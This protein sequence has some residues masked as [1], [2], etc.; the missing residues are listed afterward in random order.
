MAKRT[1]TV[2]L[3]DGS[4]ATRTTTHAYTHAVAVFY[5]AEGYTK[6]AWHVYGFTTRPEEMLRE[7]KRRGPNAPGFGGV[8]LLSVNPSEPQIKQVFCPGCGG[9]T[10]LLVDGKEVPPSDWSKYGMACDIGCIC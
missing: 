5:I 7:A 8:Q 1:L 4:I 6:P 2:T 9:M 3:P 10:K